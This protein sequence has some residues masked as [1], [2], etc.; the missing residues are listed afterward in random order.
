MKNYIKIQVLICCLFPLCLVAQKDTVSLNGSW[1]FAMDPMKSGEGQGWYTPEFASQALEP[2]EVPHCYSADPRYFAYTGTAWYFKTFQSDLPAGK[3]RAYIRFG[4]V[5]YKT[6]VWVNGSNAG[7]HEGGYTPFE[8]DITPMLKQGENVLTVQVNNEWDSTTIPGAKTFDTIYRPH[9]L[10]LYAWMNYGGITRPVS[11]I[12]RPDSYINAV[13]ISGVPD[14]KT[15]TAVVKAMVQLK[16]AGTAAIRESVS[17]GIK[18]KGVTVYE[19]KKPQQVLV[20]PD[21]TVTTWL[22]ASLPAKDVHLWNI[23]TPEL[24]EATVYTRTHT[25]TVNIGIRKIEISGT[26]LLL[27]GEAV[28]LGGANRP[29]DYPGL[30]STDPD[31]VVQK[32]LRAMKEAGLVFSR[33]AHHTAS[34]AVMDWA[35][36]NGMLLIAEA[37]N[38]QM[39][40]KQMADPMMRNKYIQQLTEMMMRDW[41]RP[42]VIAYSLGNEF[43]SN[44]KEGIDWV[45]DMGAY[46]RKMDPDR[47]ITFASHTVWRGGIKKPEDEAS[48][49]VDFI[50]A[51]IYADHAKNI[52]HIQQVYPGK[53]IYVSEFGIRNKP[54][55]EDEAARLKYL[56]NAMAAFRDCDQLIG[57]NIWTLNDY[58]SRY[59]STD[60]NGY[61]QWGLVDEHRNPRRLYYSVQQ[62][63]SPAI[64]SAKRINDASIRVEVIV[65]KDFPSH[66]LQGYSI[67]TGT[68]SWPLKTLKPGESQQLVLNV[69]KDVSAIEL[70]Q[71]QGYIILNITVTE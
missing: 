53:P 60:K 32:D 49:Y 10:Q 54:G 7:A 29:T 35:D 24:Y 21:S 59:P 12:Y 65:R 40:T 2:V 33:I 25:T 31:S 66:T 20:P 64:V 19:T 48:N 28:K 58:V 62:E 37:G 3:T 11:L 57:A 55:D 4:S 69:G 42:S 70:L 38:W 46:V 8:V 36:R 17:F 63:F 14:L 39:T 41:N 52:K 56:N 30:G 50:S 18:Y 16:N 26:K 1:Q 13:K 71:R 34:D 61:R 27:N 68:G 23:E 9:A 44:K 6:K 51:N 47:L 5:F 22:E 43:R 45:K 67:R 15:N